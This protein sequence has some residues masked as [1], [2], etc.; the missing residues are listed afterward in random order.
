MREYGKLGA[1]LWKTNSEPKEY[2]NFWKSGTHTLTRPI[3]PYRTDNR[4]PIECFGIRLD[5]AGIDT[6]LRDSGAST[7]GEPREQK[8]PSSPL[9]DAEA[10]RFAAAIVAGWP[11][12]SQDWAHEKAQ[13][14]FPDKSISRDNFRVIFRAIQGPKTP[15]KTKKTGN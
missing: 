6:I 12:A 5:P 10:R 9:S 1:F 2:E 11:E 14:F 3:D 7:D 13:L 8:P 15:G 4:Y